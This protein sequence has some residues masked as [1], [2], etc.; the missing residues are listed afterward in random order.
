[1]NHSRTQG[2]TPVRKRHA[3]AASKA[4]NP[5]PRI[6]SGELVLMPPAALMGAELV[7]PGLRNRNLVVVTKRDSNL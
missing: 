7:D 4:A 1:M 3:R 6:Y 2:R 5:V